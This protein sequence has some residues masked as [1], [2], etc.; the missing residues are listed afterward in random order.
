MKKILQTIMLSGLIV[1]ILLGSPALAAS[2]AQ[3]DTNS[4]MPLEWRLIGTWRWEGQHSWIM[5][6]REDGT[7][8]DGP[9]GLRSTYNWEVVGNSLIV[10]GAD[11][12]IQIT[13]NTI[14]VDRYGRSRSRYTYVWY[15]DSTEGATSSWFLVIIGILILSIAGAVVLSVVRRDQ[16]RK[17]QEQPQL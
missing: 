3:A 14:T 1:F 15:S 6:F 7:M 2:T 16:R 17:R 10:D 11:W 4:Q 12:N 9:P 5:V 13:G 8:L